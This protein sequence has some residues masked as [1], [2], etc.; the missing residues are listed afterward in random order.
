[1]KDLIYLAA[2]DNPRTLQNFGKSALHS[3]VR[4]VCLAGGHVVTDDAW[5]LEVFS[6]LPAV[7]ELAPALPL[8][9]VICLTLET[10][11]EIDCSNITCVLETTVKLQVNCNINIHY[12]VLYKHTSSAENYVFKTLLHNS[13][14]ICCTD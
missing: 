5:A 2:L 1:M 7:V 8:Y 6:R 3:Q 9:E 12:L 14:I 13:T 11:T 4:L 10:D